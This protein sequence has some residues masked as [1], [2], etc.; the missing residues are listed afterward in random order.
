MTTLNIH[1]IL[2]QFELVE[3]RQD[4]KKILENNN[5]HYFKEVLKY[6][7]NS[8]YE[9]YTEDKFPAD[10]QQPDTFLGLRLAGIESEHRKAYLFLK[11][12]PTAESL[13]E[14]KRHILLLQLLES[15]EPKEA[16]IWFNMMKKDLKT[17]G[18]TRS[19]VEEVYPELLV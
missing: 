1:E 12:D 5:L 4:R 6:T 9:F 10:Y 17:K 18:L 3:T 2:D 14:Q 7:F 16:K 13:T 11:G 8:K 15:F 19:L